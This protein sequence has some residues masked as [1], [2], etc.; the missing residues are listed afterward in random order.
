M[1]LLSVC[2]YVNDFPRD[3]TKQIEPT[4]AKFGTHDAFKAPW[5]GIDYGSKMSKVKVARV[6]SV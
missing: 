6:E 3:K 5:S 4:I 2:K 1:T